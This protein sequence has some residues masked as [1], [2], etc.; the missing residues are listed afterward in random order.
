MAL[1]DLKVS[2]GRE[3]EFQALLDKLYKDYVDELDLMV[4][5]AADEIETA[6]ERGL[7]DKQQIVTDW[8]QTAAQRA[9]DYY[10][11]V[12]EAWKE[13]A[14]VD[15]PP[16]DSYGLVD[17]NQALWETQSQLV[18]E[19][20]IGMRYQDA[21]S[22]HT[23]YGV[24]IQDLWPSM[25][26]IDDAQQFIADM[27]FNSARL[28]T[29]H[30]M[31]HDPTKPRWARV[32]SGAKTCAFC[33]ML[34]SRGFA[35]LSDET[36]GRGGSRYHADCDCKVIPSWGKQTLKG[37]DLDEYQQIY[38]NAH[39]AGEDYKKTLQRIRREAYDKVSDGVEPLKNLPWDCPMA[40]TLGAR[41]MRELDK[42]L[43]ESPHQ[44]AVK[45]WA[46]HFQDFVCID[47]GKA[48]RPG[49][50]FSPKLGGI[51]I[52]IN[53]LDGNDGAP[54]GALIH[55]CTHMLDW[56]LGSNGHLWSSMEHSG[57]RVAELLGEEAMALYDK[58]AAAVGV[59]ISDIEAIDRTVKGMIDEINGLGT[60]S[61]WDVHDMV[62]AGL[63][64]SIGGY[65]YMTVRYGHRV[66][67]YAANPSRRSAEPFA[68]MMTAQLVND[69]LWKIVQKVFPKTSRWFNSRIGS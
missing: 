37:Y 48:T 29:M 51:V 8:T 62:E 11:A 10:Q 42:V 43:S 38:E 61:S 23:K 13:Y 19:R 35:Y 9:D 22:G 56:Q 12:R 20:Y 16:L 53:S 31:R 39:H 46:S 49:V 28:Q 67:Y 59:N 50:Y 6:V 30:D 5:E 66:G 55:E 65:Y 21:I 1:N 54:F 18:N 25:E 60:D 34:A 15:M 41:R 58:H 26:N 27:M 2:P 36:A 7:V 63:P 68:E 33:M 40:Q 3:E 17:V 4:E 57:I 32:P 47:N 44:D 64:E 14:G 52:D 45:F 69:D 24:T